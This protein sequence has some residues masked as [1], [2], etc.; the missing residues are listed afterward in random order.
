MFFP[1]IGFIEFANLSVVGYLNE[2]LFTKKTQES[3]L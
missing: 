1:G 2:S 3:I